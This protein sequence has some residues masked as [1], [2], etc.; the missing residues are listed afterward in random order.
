MYCLA[1]S[2]DPEALWQSRKIHIDFSAR[3]LIYQVSGIDFENKTPVERNLLDQAATEA[4]RMASRLPLE[5]M[6]HQTWALLL[7]HANHRQSATGAF[8]SSIAERLDS[9]KGIMRLTKPLRAG[10]EQ[11]VATYVHRQLNG[12]S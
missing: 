9:M 3:K 4:Y 12:S 8:G 5:D 6:S 11:A 10:V 1:D 2:P 7:L